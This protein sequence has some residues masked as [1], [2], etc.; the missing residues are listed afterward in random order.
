[1]RNC[2]TLSHWFLHPFFESTHHYVLHLGR[3]LRRSRLLRR[4]WL[5]LLWSLFGDR[6]W[7]FKRSR[8]L[9]LTNRFLLFWFW[10]GCGH[11]LLAIDKTLNINF[12][13]SSSLARSCDFGSIQ[14]IFFN[15]SSHIGRHHYFRTCYPWWFL[16]IIT[17]GGFDFSYGFIIFR[18]DFGRTGRLVIGEYLQ[19]KIT[20]L[21]DILLIVVNLADYSWIWRSNLR[22]LLIGSDIRQFLKLFHWI[23]LF[24]V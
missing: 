6:R 17:L 3:V 22:K 5:M 2:V 7:W 9:N 16:F 19:K 4:L 18:S 24:H 14:S 1:M 12:Q 13:N 10:F 8:L 23:T 21:A 11:L 20:N 15:E